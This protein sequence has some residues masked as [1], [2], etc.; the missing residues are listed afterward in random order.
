MRLSRSNKVLLFGA[1]EAAPRNE[2]PEMGESQTGSCIAENKNL[3]EETLAKKFG[4]EPTR[5]G[6]DLYF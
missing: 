5:S 6:K 4:C 1:H 2:S 3:L